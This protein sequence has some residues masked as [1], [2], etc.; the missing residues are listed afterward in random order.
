MAANPN[1]G[2]PLLEHYLKRYEEVEGERP[3]IN[4]T[5]KVWA[6]ADMYEDLR[7]QAIPVIDYFFDNYENGYHEIDRLMFNYDTLFEEMK[8]AEV[9]KKRRLRIAAETAE[10][11]KNFGK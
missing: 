10:R 8:E 4:R 11:V 2:K 6:F 5:K 1:K 7:D 9:E 3:V